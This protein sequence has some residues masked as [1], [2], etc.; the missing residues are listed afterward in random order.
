MPAVYPLGRNVNL[1]IGRFFR[2]G[3]C[4]RLNLLDDDDILT[5]ESTDAQK[6]MAVERP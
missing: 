1:I 3:D 5:I 4:W 2:F 6:S